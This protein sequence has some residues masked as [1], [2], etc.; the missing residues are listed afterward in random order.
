MTND[1]RSLNVIYIVYDCKNE[2]H[3]SLLI[4]HY[5]LLITH[6]SLLITQYLEYKHPLKTP[7]TY[8]NLLLKFT[9]YFY[10]IKQFIHKQLLP[11]SNE[12]NLIQFRIPDR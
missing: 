3:W 12:G 5:S 8:I 10:N 4:T 7:C 6:Y 2:S 11:C 1:F 9:W